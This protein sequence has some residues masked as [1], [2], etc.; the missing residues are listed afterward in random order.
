MYSVQIDYIKSTSRRIERTIST[1][2]MALREAT[3]GMAGGER[4]RHV[5][6]DTNQQ[7]Y[8]NHMPPPVIGGAL[9]DGSRLLLNSS[10]T[11]KRTINKI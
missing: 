8:P 3:V 11:T 5:A 7:G 6:G 2:G 9:G 10:S 4:M 1:T